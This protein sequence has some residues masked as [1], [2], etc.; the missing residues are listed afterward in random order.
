MTLQTSRRRVRLTLLA[1][2]AAMA[3]AACENQPLDFDL[4][5]LTGGFSTSDAAVNAVADRPRPDSR[6]VISYPN[7]QVAVAKRGDTILDVAQRVGVNAQTLGRFN[8][9]A[10][11]VP[12]RDG[13]I[14]ALPTRV[15]EPS[16]ATGARG[17]G[18]IQPAGVDIGSLAGGAIDRVPS[19]AGVQTQTLDAPTPA[20]APRQTGAEPVRHKVERGESAYTVA[21]LYNVPVKALAEWNGLGPDFAI[22]EG[23][24]LL[25]PV[26]S[27]KPPSQV[28]AQ[29]QPSADVTA[30]GSGSPTPTPPSA[31]KP[32]PQEKVAP[33]KPAPTQTAAAAPPP[34]PVADVGK[35]TKTPKPAQLVTPV[36]GTIIRDYAK[37]KNEG[38]N[39]KAAPG[40]PVKVADSGTVAA[41][42]KSGEG[43]PIVVVRHANNLLTVY[44][45]VTDVSVKK[46]DSVKRGQAIAKLRSG[47]DSFVHFEV[48]QGFDSVDPNPF[49]NG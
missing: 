19:T 9:I 46:G 18:P 42:T 23:Q 47:D 30:P 35:T 10:T 25:I 48:R 24:F 36:T 41:I 16:P 32:L 22:R 43:V 13:E 39:I 49:L 37:G 17:T 44:A 12:L 20:A 2:A 31:V 15:A 4:R 33:A 45:N 1:G 6:G 3:L 7:Y 11:D 27:Q 38:I 26:A 29:A 40:T 28:Q 34:K 14:I 8:G 21:R 5:G